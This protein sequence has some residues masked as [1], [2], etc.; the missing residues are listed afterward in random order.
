MITPHRTE[1]ERLLDLIDVSNLVPGD[2]A[3]VALVRAVLGVDDAIT[4]AAGVIANAIA[5]SA[6]T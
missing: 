2:L 5:E 3:T 4:E 1:A 6:G